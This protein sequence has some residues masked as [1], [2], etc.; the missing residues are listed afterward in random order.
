[1]RRST[2]KTY[3]AVSTKLAQP[4]RPNL[5]FAYVGRNQMIARW[6]G[7]EWLHPADGAALSVTRWLRPVTMRKVPIPS[8]GV[9]Q[10][11]G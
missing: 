5:Y 9:F 11:I 7:T 2:P 10:I 8:E 6:T 1:M 3:V 4:T